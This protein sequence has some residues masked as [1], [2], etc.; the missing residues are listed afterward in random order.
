MT[1]RPILFSA[2]MVRAIIDGRKTQT[3]RA[4]T[5]F[6]VV[7]MASNCTGPDGYDVAI[8]LRRGNR[9]ERVPWD[10]ESAKRLICPYGQPGDRLWVR[11]AFREF[12]PS[13]G[14]VYRAEL[15]SAEEF[16]PADWKWKPSIHMPRKAS[17]ITLEIT[18]VRVQRVCE[19]SAED[20]KAEGVLPLNRADREPNRSDCKALW[21][22]INAKREG[23]IYAW[24]KNPWCWCITFKMVNQERAN[25]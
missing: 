17:R 22:K 23:G 24:D 8:Q 10:V 2:E 18:E 16:K 19:I 13:G 5:K 25:A 9:I 3:R 11:E 14:F 12:S 20:C 21:D 4:V 6:R 1:E 15:Q 7:G